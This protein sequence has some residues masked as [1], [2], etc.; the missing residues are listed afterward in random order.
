LRVDQ[1]L[2][3]LALF[4]GFLDPPLPA[5]GDDRAGAA[6]VQAGDVTQLRVGHRRQ[7]KQ[8]ARRVL[9]GDAAELPRVLAGLQRPVPIAGIGRR[10]VAGNEDLGRGGRSEG[11]IDDDPAE[12]IPRAGDLGRERRGGHAG[13]QHH[14]VGSENAVV[15]EVYTVCRQGSH[16]GAEAQLDTGGRQRRLDLRPRPGPELRPDGLGPV[17]QYDAQSLGYTIGAVHQQ[18]V[19]QLE[20]QLDAG[21][22]GADTAMV[23]SATSRKI[24]PR[25]RSKAIASAWVSIESAASAPGT[26][27]R[28][29]RLPVATTKRS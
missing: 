21:K 29:M 1:P 20:R 13:R 10:G 16:G 18:P 14:G 9:A 23:G 28:R 6:E 3:R 4:V 12:L 27:G 15:S 7:A 8:V 24:S 5:L 2:H 26:G 22:A 19:A 11:S 25:R 17:D